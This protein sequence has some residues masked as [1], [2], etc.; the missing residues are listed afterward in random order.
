ML[1]TE[2]LG[3]NGLQAL[4][5]RLSG[6]LSR[7][8]R[9]K[10]LSSRPDRS[11]ND[12]AFFEADLR[13][14]FT[15]TPVVVDLSEH[16]YADMDR[17][18]EELLVSLD[19]MV[20][21]DLVNIP[22]TSIPRSPDNTLPE[23]LSPK[24]HDITLL[25]KNYPRLSSLL[26]SLDASSGQFNLTTGAGSLF[27][28]PLGKARSIA[29]DRVAQWKTLLERFAGGNKK[30]QDPQVTSLPQAEFELLV[31][32]THEQSGGYQ[33]HASVLVN[34]I[35]EEFRQRNCV[36]THEIKLRVPD[37]RQGGTGKAVLDMFVSSC[38]DGDV[39]QQAV[40]GSFQVTVNATEK[41]SLCAAIQR[42]IEQ[43]RKLYLFFNQRELFD[44][45]DK[46]PPL[47][48]SSDNFT[49]ESLSQLLDQKVFTR[50]T[51]RDYLQGETTEKYDS[52]QK[53]ALALALA[54]CLMDFFDEDV[55]LASYSWKPESVFFLRPVGASTG[56]RVLYISL[57]P[58]SLNTK[59]PDLLK[60]VKPG[61]PIL[62]SFAKLLLEIDN[63][64][65]LPI[66]IHP[67]SRTNV[68]KWGDICEFIETA[69]KE[70]SGSY[71]RAVEGCLY[72]HRALPRPS[73]QP[74]DSTASEILRKA[75]YEQIVR[76]LEL[77]VNPQ[78]SK[79][80][81]R[82]SVSELPMAKKLSILCPTDTESQELP[83]YRGT[84]IPIKKTT[85]P[86]SRDDFEVAIVC[87]LPLEYDAV[88]L[89]I[90]EFWEEDY[91]VADGD[92]NIYTTGRIGKFNVV[93]VLLPNMGK[94]IAA[95]TAASLRIS[96]QALSLVLV[97]GICGGVPRPGTDEEILLGDVVISR[98][99]IQY[100]YG[101]KYPDEFTMKDAVE[102]SLGRAPKNVRNLL[103]MFKT[104]F[105]RER[106]ERRTAIHLRELQKAAQK[107]RG[108]KYQYPGASQDKLFH[109]SYQHKH[110]HSL[111]CLCAK[112]HHNKLSFQ[113][114]KESRKLLCDELGC[115]DKHLVSRER[116]ECK[117]QLE[118]VGRN[119]DAQVP[120]IFVGR[121]GSGDTVMKSGE[122]R[123]SI[124][125]RYGL[126]AFEMES[127]GVWDEFPSCIVVKAVC[128]YADSHKNEIWQN[129]AAATAASATKALLEKYIGGNGPR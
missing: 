99:V 66:E 121:I 11:Q 81:R 129:F 29:M 47:S 25:A 114:C 74:N 115:D 93:L 10:T 31:K 46:M 128:D 122:D 26:A 6:R 51:P 72:L 5:S 50:I 8:T 40:C 125:D 68:P 75:I 14:I 77:M 48:L 91:G 12:A 109:P 56:N 3:W 15:A 39:W 86:S 88:S 42:A 33:K 57:K 124:A 55:E 34:A 64:E 30:S 89:L 59:P 100:D 18:T 2:S 79:R 35:F 1:S 20:N 22:E 103:V 92:P 13:Y 61:N 28:L 17:T 36:G 62:L 63:G 108:P 24:P 80:K 94:V 7:F 85:P 23:P 87:A 58:K 41:E 71:L 4:K 52:R 49:A 45:S 102:D 126:L 60:T 21:D 53:A 83:A 97:T 54:R 19:Y 32:P 104:N 112:P 65:R 120:S 69:A 117:E 111:H 37:E 127:A 105:L 116:L 70:G 106:L 98:H 90:D 113:A 73:D 67:D 96:F 84:K 110:H 38:S 107:Q 78:T 123:D 27:A 119:K 44:I 76:N 95:G 16:D 118:K 43:S 82:D 101:K 9:S